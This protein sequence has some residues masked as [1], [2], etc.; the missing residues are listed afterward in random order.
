MGL[1][2][3][4]EALELE[5]QRS[6]KEVEQR[7][8]EQAKRI[9]N[10][11]SSRAEEAKKEILQSEKKK[12]EQECKN[13]IYAAEAEARKIIAK[14]REDV[15]E[16]VRKSIL[17][18]LKKDEEIRKRVYESALQEIFSY[19]NGQA[20]SYELVSSPLAKD[21]IES[22]VGKLGKK[23][24]VSTANGLSSGFEVKG[25]DGKVVFLVTPE[26]I[27]DRLLKSFVAEISERL[28]E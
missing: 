16:L 9:K 25:E 13:I 14:A 10:E 22:L 28:F 6:I 26:V 3:I 8:L 1:K 7:A 5:A 12:I 11:S 18:F 4:L 27:A 17:E 2:E 23:I 20:G 15:F 19:L 24:P 21:E